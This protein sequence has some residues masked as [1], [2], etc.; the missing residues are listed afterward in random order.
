M[1]IRP[2]LR[3]LGS[4]RPGRSAL[5][6]RI[7]AVVPVAAWQSALPWI[8]LLLLALVAL[9]A[10]AVA[11]GRALRARRRAEHDFERMFQLSVDGLLVAGVD[12]YV[13]RANPAVERMLGY[14]QD[15]LR[16]RRMLELVHPDDRAP[17]REQLST[18]AR[19]E[20]LAQVQTRVARADG[21]LVLVEW[22]ARPVPEEGLFFAAS[23]DI[24]QRHRIEQALELLLD[25]QAALRRVA[26]LVA[27]EASPGEIRD[28]VVR[29][30]RLL[31]AAD[32]TRLL[33]YEGAGSATL[34]AG[35]DGPG[36]AIELGRRLSLGGE[37]AATLVRRS[38]RAARMRYSERE[39]GDIAERLRQLELRLGVGA[40]VSVGG[41]LWGVMVAAWKD[42]SAPPEDAE[43]RMAQFTELIGVAIA[44]A[45]DR[46][47]LAAS[48]ARVVRTADETRRRIERDLHD[49]IQQRLV[50]LGLELRTAEAALPA[51]RE[52]VRRQV[53][54]AAATV[55]ELIAEVQ[56]ISRG[57][58]PAILTTGGLGPALRTLARRSPVP[59]ELD[60]RVARRLPEA[61]E[62]AIYFVASEALANAAK[63]AD[64]SV[65][66]IALHAP[67]GAV[68]LAVVDDGVGG[69]DP[70]R[71]S[72]LVGL[73]DRVEALGG[74]IDIASAAG[75]GTSVQVSIP[76]GE[77]TS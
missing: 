24:T 3:A 63:H 74:A 18:L 10:V 41:R 26:L 7:G 65:V 13:R 2:C 20:Q 71:G 53:G 6:V 9:V 45:E 72:G 64:A 37:N 47:Q 69:A 56:E 33:R 36:R 16:A 19:G 17:F 57:I 4:L 39:T 32:S 21:E 62:A 27:R 70:A 59:V 8:A 12:G 29:E 50:S 1:P 48:R 76:T 14:T 46:T 15:E 58:H 61:V 54:A 40:P 35:D 60:D 66:R 38:G 42:P 34:I 22:S 68:E 55:V 52:D 25:E 5:V 51:D 31:L 43:Q 23:R 67:D 73:Q 44:N 30:V 49:T 77:R 75:S 28:A 11:V